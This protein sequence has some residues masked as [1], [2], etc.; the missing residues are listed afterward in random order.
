MLTI[1]VVLEGS[2]QAPYQYVAQYF[3]LWKCNQRM[4]L[5]PTF[6]STIGCHETN[7]ICSLHASFL[8]PILTYKSSNSC[9]WSYLCMTTLVITAHKPFLATVLTYIMKLLR[10]RRQF[11]YTMFYSCKLPTECPME[12]RSA[13]SA[14]SH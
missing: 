12:I 7:I 13:N 2:L 11:A 6:Q 14:N 8:F 5:I 1:K 4:K 3:L 10:R 9:L